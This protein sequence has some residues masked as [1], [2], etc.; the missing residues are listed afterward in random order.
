MQSNAF[1][2]SVRARVYAMI[3][4]FC[5]FFNFTLATSSG[6]PVLENKPNPRGIPLFLP[7]TINFKTTTIKK[8]IEGIYEISNI[9]NARLRKR[10]A[11][12]VMIIHSKQGRLSGILT[13]NVTRNVKLFDASVLSYL[14]GRQ[15]SH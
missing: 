2:V 4:F 11:F 8:S 12:H 5:W 10:E 6:L 9:F 14:G 1:T 3:G 15:M 13:E 7:N